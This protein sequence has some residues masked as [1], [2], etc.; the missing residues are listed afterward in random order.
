[1]LSVKGFSYAKEPNNPR[2][3]R[4][5]KKGC[6]DNRA[7]HYIKSYEDSACVV[8]ESNKEHER[9]FEEARNKQSYRDVIARVSQ[10]K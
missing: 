9:I 4:R 2:F 5:M 1:M 7:G 8:C 6:M 10:A 3:D